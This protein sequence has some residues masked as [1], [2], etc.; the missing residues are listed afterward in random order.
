MDD[1]DRFTVFDGKTQQIDP[2]RTLRVKTVRKGQ[3]VAASAQA[4]KNYDRIFG[5]RREGESAP[6]PT[7]DDVKA[8]RHFREN[9]D[10]IFGA[11]EAAEG[12]DSNG[13]EKRHV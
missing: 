10:R 3:M 13:K 12:D 9:F 4:A 5:K 11:H 1:D 2:K 6:A 8:K 7:P